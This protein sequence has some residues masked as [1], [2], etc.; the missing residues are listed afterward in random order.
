M[1]ILQKT[2]ARCAVLS[3][4]AVAF[5]LGLALMP[6][7]ARKAE[8]AT[9]FKVSK[10]TTE[11]YTSIAAGDTIQNDTSDEYK[12][13]LY[14]FEY[15]PT[16]FSD[17]LVETTNNERHRLCHQTTIPAGESI[18]L[19][20]SYAS[21]TD[22]EGTI[23]CT[24]VQLAARRYVYN[25]SNKVIDIYQKAPETGWKTLK[26]DNQTTDVVESIGLSSSDAIEEW[27]FDEDEMEKAYY[28]GEVY[29]WVSYKA[30]FD[31]SS[32]KV[33]G[34]NCS[35]TTTQGFFEDDEE[36]EEYV[37]WL[38]TD[39]EDNATV[40]VTRNT[41]QAGDYHTYGDATYQW[42]KATDEDGEPI[43]RCAY[44]CTATR[45]CIHGDDTQTETVSVEY[46][47][48]T[49]E[50]DGVATEATCGTAGTAYYT[51]HFVSSA[52]KDQT[53]VLENLDDPATGEH[54]FGN[55]EVTDAT[56]T[57]DGRRVS[58]C[59]VCGAK[60]IVVLPATGGS[61]I[62]SLEK[63]ALIAASARIDDATLETTKSDLLAMSGLFEENQKTAVEGGSNAK[64]WLEFPKDVSAVSE[65]NAAKVLAAAKSAVGSDAQIYYFDVNLYRFYNDETEQISTPR[66]SIRFTISIPE[67]LRK[68]GRIYSVIRLNDG[69]AT[70]LG[71]TYDS[72]NPTT[73]TLESDHFSTYAIAYSDTGSNSGN[74][75]SGND[76]NADGSDGSNQDSSSD[77]ETTAETT[78][79]AA[80]TG[81]S[82]KTDDVQNAWTLV[83]AML[84][85]AASFAGLARW[86]N[87]KRS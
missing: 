4:L 49:K 53:V 68:A 18:T 9:T 66:G 34:T 47:D 82:P 25:D 8:A 40:T 71:G 50:E 42:E 65:E 3:V 26:L 59:T 45:S 39:I 62:G 67:S 19:A 35:V 43:Y 55:P 16:R 76:G 46:I 44:K 51:A 2:P 48:E 75:N 15:Y 61:D 78:A 23:S 24:A 79:A 54:T 33:T 30:G 58:I 36:E 10:I 6:Q 31:D 80:V 29:L 21:N 83:C 12:L 7:V 64:V 86:M 5:V 52:F 69:V 1:R 70:N 38:I 63:A 73:I 60:Q 41:C 14:S 13:R 17:T 32:L 27:D 74:N 57:T 84:A 11:N 28:Y 87:Q 37:I 81:V 56:E 72:T 20:D 22:T 85:A 77:A